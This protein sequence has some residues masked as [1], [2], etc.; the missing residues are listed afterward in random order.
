MEPK[1]QPTAQGW[2]TFTDGAWG[3]A[4]AG[5]SA[6]LVAPSGVR[7]KFAARLEFKSTNNIAEYE[8]L[9]LALSKAKALGA[10]ILTVK[11]DSQVVTSQVEKEYT[12]REPELV[13]YL[14][15]VR[16]LERRF[17]GFTLK[18]ILRSENVEADELAKAAA[19]N[20]PLPPNTFYQI[21]KS[22]TTAETSKASKPILYLQ[23]EDWRKVI[24]EFLEG[25]T[26]QE[27]EAKAAR[28]QARARNYTIIDGVLYKKGV[29]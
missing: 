13:K 17:K 15:V 10:K 20:L 2:I 12:A 1:A 26:T 22:P 14:S 8:G 7:L 16:N 5:A 4:R 27:D 23:N 28:I 29:V 24:P 6:V 18:H 11:I 21:L 9:I 19:N 25:K 3:Q